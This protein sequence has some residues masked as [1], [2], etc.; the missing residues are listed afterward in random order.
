MLPLPWWGWDAAF[1]AGCA[2]LEERFWQLMLEGLR[3]DYRGAC[4]AMGCGEAVRSGSACE[5]QGSEQVGR[6]CR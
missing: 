1:R 3:R 5:G 6:V 4:V 2:I